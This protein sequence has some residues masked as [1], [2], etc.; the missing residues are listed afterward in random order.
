MA[1]DILDEVEQLGLRAEQRAAM[2]GARLLVD[3]FVLAH[4]LG[5]RVK[6]ALRQLHAVVGSGQVDRV[7]VRHQV[8][9]HRAAAAAGGFGP[10]RHLFFEIDETVAGV[11][12]GGVDFPVHLHRNEVFD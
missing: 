8:A 6:G 9:K 12:R 7:D 10:V 1:A 5:E 3:G 2:H 11:D 4:Q